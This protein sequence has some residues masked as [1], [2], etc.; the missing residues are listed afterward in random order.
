MA[1]NSTAVA[2][3]PRPRLPKPNYLQVNDDTWQILIDM[4]YPTATDPNVIALAWSVCQH[5][6]LDIFRKPFHITKMW[7]A[8]AGREVEQIIP[9]INELLVTAARTGEFAGNDLPVYGP[10]ITETF[11]GRRKKR[12]QWEDVEVTVSYPETVSITVYRMVKGTARPFT[13]PV[14]WKEEYMRVGGGVVPNDMWA[15]RTFDQ[16]QKVALAASLRLAFPDVA[17]PEPEDISIATREVEIIEHEPQRAQPPRQGLPEPEQPPPQTEPPMDPETG[18]VGP[19]LIRFVNNQQ[20]EP[21]S[22]QEWGARMIAAV[23]SSATES[24]IDQWVTANAEPMEQFK[25]EAAVVF[26]RMEAAVNKHRN[27]LK[28][29]QTAKS[30]DK[31]G[32]A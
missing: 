13:M 7:N 28:A 31:G 10:T 26:G 22:W 27:R 5:R 14:R 17:E 1:T 25:K 20:G 3:R 24:E 2:M 9:G 19:H 11:Q 15:R 12:D 29:Q 6:K 4:T 16:C 8:L 23:N 30:D 18:E 21:E 32:Q